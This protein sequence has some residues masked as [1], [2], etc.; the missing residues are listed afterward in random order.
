MAEKGLTFVREKEIDIYYRGQIIDSRRV[1]FLVE[2]NILVELKALTQLEAVHL[3]QAKNY[4]EAFNLNIGLLINFGETSLRFKRLQLSWGK[5][6]KSKNPSNP[7][8]DNG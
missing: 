6:P 4:L 8:S 3:A 5:S 7:G 1:D 2:D